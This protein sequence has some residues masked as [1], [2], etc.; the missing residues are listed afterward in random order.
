VAAVPASVEA[1]HSPWCGM[2][3]AVDYVLIEGAEV[4]F[5]DDFVMAVIEGQDV[6][7]EC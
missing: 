7:V 4:A 3:D 5:V 2:S 6:V 1:D